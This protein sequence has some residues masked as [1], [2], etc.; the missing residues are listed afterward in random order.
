MFKKIRKLMQENQ[1]RREMRK[2]AE[3]IEHH[4]TMSRAH[5]RTAEQ[6]EERAK[7]LRGQSL[8]LTLQYARMGL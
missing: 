3:D 5:L 4:R 6:L 1:L 8:G 2:L 7:R